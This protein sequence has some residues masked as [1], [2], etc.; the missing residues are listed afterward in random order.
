MADWC[1]GPISTVAFSGAV[2]AVPLVLGTSDLDAYEHA[3][4][5]LNRGTAVHAVH[6]LGH[7]VYTLAIGLGVRLPLLPN[8]G[9]SLAA[10]VVPY[11]PAPLTYWL[12]V[13]CAVA[14]AA[15]VVRCAL[16]P[17]C[18][19]LLSWTAL[20]LLFVSAPVVNY[21]LTDDGHT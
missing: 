21:T 5:S 10:F 15:F 18:G 14:L 6:L 16:E 9:A 20:L 2:A 19:R 3:F 11:V 8:L 13:T 12:L 17:H 4:F 7:P 1:A